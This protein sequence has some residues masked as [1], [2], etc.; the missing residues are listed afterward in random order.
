MI[1]AVDSVADRGRRRRKLWNTEMANVRKR[2]RK[3]SG[4][5]N[6]EMANFRRKRKEEEREEMSK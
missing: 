6:K 3:R 5:R 1:D 2:R 4:R